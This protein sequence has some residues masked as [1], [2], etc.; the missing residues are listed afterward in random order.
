M[1]AQDVQPAAKSSEGH[2]AGLG[3]A[4]A[5]PTLTTG[6]RT[7]EKHY[8]LQA[9]MHMYERASERARNW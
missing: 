2:H 9:G 7:D 5:P 4:E 6:T 8:V 1:C 3:E